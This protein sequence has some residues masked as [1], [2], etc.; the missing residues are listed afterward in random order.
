MIKPRM[1]AMLTESRMMMLL[2]GLA[3]AACSPAGDSG[4]GA[5]DQGG[6]QGTG[7]AGT[8]A[9]G[10]SG[11]NA[12]GGAGDGGS[13]GSEPNPTGSG[14]SGAG[15]GS[16]GSDVPDAAGSGGNA[17]GGDQGAG[18]SG[19]G[20]GGAGADDA[21]APLPDGP[22]GGMGQGAVL[23]WGHG[24]HGAANG[25]PIAL[26]V[27]LMALLTTKGLKVEMV[28]DAMAAATDATGKALVVISSSVDRALV[29][30][31]YKDVTV[32]AIVIKDGCFGPMGMGTDGVSGVGLSK[33]TI[34]AAGDPLAAG[35]TGD[36]AVYT[37]TDRMIYSAPGP[38]AKKI[39]SMVGNPAQ[40]TI[41]AYDAGAMMVGGAKAAAKRLG[42]FI[43]RDTDLNA[44]GKKLFT[45]AVDWALQ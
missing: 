36:V 14:G 15:G 4:G 22:S 34:L 35:L 43:H 32:P 23:V 45:A 2:L 16:G 13:G 24:E 9:T 6:S 21:A 10:G 17:T 27:D 42:F 12:S 3:C 19:G 31:K 20:A 26:D 40:L 8:A 7:G 37:T 28:R 33:L 38:G 29:L 18:G 5:G 44:N 25:P 1:Q 11:G 39:A 30:G 41:F